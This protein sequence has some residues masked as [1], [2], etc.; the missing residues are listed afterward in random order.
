MKEFVTNL[1][2]M[3]LV[4]A[5]AMWMTPYCLAAIMEWILCAAAILW[6]LPNVFFV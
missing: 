2:T 1:T 4:V 3:L 6:F 5:A